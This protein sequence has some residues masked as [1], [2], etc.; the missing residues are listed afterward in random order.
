[1]GDDDW[2]VP[3][4]PE[5]VRQLFA[6]GNW[7]MEDPSPACSCSCDGKKKMLPDCPAGAGGMPPPEV[8]WGAA[9]RPSRGGR[10]PFG[11]VRL[12]FR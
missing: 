1:M 12:V 8:S 6:S 11:D 2:S 4:V 7:T 5:S 9:A 3:E 10:G